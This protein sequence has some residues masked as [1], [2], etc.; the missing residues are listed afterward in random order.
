MHAS[1][2]AQFPTLRLIPVDSEKVPV[3]SKIINSGWERVF[4]ARKSGA[5]QQ[6][7][8]TVMVT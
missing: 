6:N 8:V 7:I 1:G 5:A 2:Y 3:S 4:D